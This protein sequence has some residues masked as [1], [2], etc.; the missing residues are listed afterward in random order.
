MPKNIQD[1]RDHP[2]YALERHLKR[3][4]VISPR[5]EVGKVTVGKGAVTALEPV[6]RRRDVQIVRTSDKWYRLG[7]EIKV[8][9]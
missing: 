3:Q 6:Y 2:V 4:E 5:R 7:R 1:F 9:S 8:G